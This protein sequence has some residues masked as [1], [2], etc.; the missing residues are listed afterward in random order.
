[1]PSENFHNRE[2]ISKSEEETISLARDIGKKFRGDEVVLLEGELGA[3]KTIFVKGLSEG[4]GMKNS[5]EVNSPSFTIL[6]IYQGRFWI[7][8]FDLYRIEEDFEPE[9]S[10]FL[11]K[12]VVIIEWADKL[13]GKFKGIHIKIEILNENTRK[14]V[15]FQDI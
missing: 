12:G 1:M 10:D 5:E 9:I 7:F 11:N 8:H 3:G 6:N 2:F 15:I 14:I 13:K 4:L